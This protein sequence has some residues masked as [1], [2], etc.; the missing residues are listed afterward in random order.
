MYCNPIDQNRQSENV[1]H[2][3]D[4]SPWKN[5]GHLGMLR[6]TAVLVVLTRRQSS[7]C[8]ALQ[9]MYHCGVGSEPPLRMNGENSQDPETKPIIS[10]VNFITPDIPM[11]QLEYPW[12]VEL[13]N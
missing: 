8:V 6:A 2:C 9:S 7:A 12:P 13:I 4:N 10:D 1:K 5:L 3:T 11:Y